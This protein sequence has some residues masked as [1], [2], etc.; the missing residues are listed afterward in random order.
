MLHVLLQYGP[1]TYGILLS[2]TRKEFVLQLI[3]ISS[4]FLL[5]KIALLF[6]LSIADSIYS[7]ICKSTLM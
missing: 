7:T 3:P 1:V 6:I 4:E 2:T 5:D